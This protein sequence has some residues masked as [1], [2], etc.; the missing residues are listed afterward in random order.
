VQESN[1]AA[2]NKLG[3]ALA[4]QKR[5]REAADA[6]RQALAVQ[7]DYAAAHNNL[8]IVLKDLGELAD[9]EASF[10]RALALKPDYAAAFMNL[11][12]VLK[13]QGKL[14]EALA[15]YQHAVRLNPHHAQA[16]MNLGNVQRDRG[17][18]EEA[19]ASYEHAIRLQPESPDIYYNLGIALK[20]QHK[21]DEAAVSLQKAVRLRPDHA[22]A[23]L[24]LAE[25]QKEQGKFDEA[26]AGYREALR[27]KPDFFEVYFNLGNVLVDQGRL[28]EAIAHYQEAVLR[29]PDF[30]EA[31]LNLGNAQRDR[32]QTEG[33]IESYHKVLRL[34]PDFADAHNNLGIALRE[35]GKHQEAIACYREALRL[36]PGNANAHFN[37]GFVSLQNGDFEAGWREYEW[38]W[39]CPK[40]ALQRLST[41]RPVWDGSPLDGRTIYL[42]SEQGLGDTLQFIRYARLV[43]ERGGRVIV[44]CQPPLLRL[45]QSCMGIDELVPSP[46]PQLPPDS[47]PSPEQPIRPD[48]V[49][50]DFDVHAP[51]LSVPRILGTAAIPAQIPYLA[52]DAALVRAW[53]KKLSCMAGFKVGIVWRGSPRY[54]ADRHRSIALHHLI[55]LARVR[56]VHLFSLQKHHGGEELPSL[57]GR[58]PLHDLSSR[59]D[60]AAGPF[61]DTAAVLKNLDLLIAADTA[62]AHLAGALGVPVWIALT[63]AQHWVWLT[64]R[65]DSPWYPTARLFRQKER[66]N[67]DEVFER[68]ATELEVVSR[69]SQAPP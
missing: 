65:N 36:D 62:I 48:P 51:L 5:L 53:Q 17:M 45:L 43:K 15:S 22:E 4:A 66:G 49:L 34:K 37:L 41:S 32:G 50:P 9:A 35:L 19:V 8:G 27:H 44:G 60:G 6:F 33:G 13:Q 68:I 11:G 61:M 46:A 47:I 23:H 52:A 21:L 28:D 10:Q 25:V 54:S 31:Y 40:F 3:T 14:D 38:R 26:I 69:N 55:P 29:K 24:L 56:G 58:L 67:W 20:D 42:H 64:G 1:A 39:R 7:P 18:I 12:N 16:H 2:Y 63:Y 57:L 59:L 30:A